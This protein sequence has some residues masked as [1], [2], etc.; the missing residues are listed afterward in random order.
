MKNNIIQVD[1][2]EENKV[3]FKDALNGLENYFDLF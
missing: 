2:E 3:S 1:M